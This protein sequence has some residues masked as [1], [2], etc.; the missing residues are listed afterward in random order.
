[1]KV[2]STFL[3]KKD[4][5]VTLGVTERCIY[6]YIKRGY[7]RPVKDGKR[8]GVRKE[9]VIEFQECMNSDMPFPV[10]KITMSR[11]VGQIRKLQE[12]MDTVKRMLNLRRRSIDLTGQELSSAYASAQYFIANGCPMGISE[13]WSDFF[14]RLTE[15]DLSKM[16]KEKEDPHPWRV[17]YKLCNILM[18]VA[19]LNKDKEA[20][21]LLIVG[22]A[23]LK[24]LVSIW[25]EMVGE[26][27]GRMQQLYDRDSALSKRVINR[28]R[29]KGPK[30]QKTA[31]YL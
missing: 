12:E 8:V 4:A 14:V 29:E 23:N 20:E 2:G 10:N 21:E 15:E 13:P 24:T 9:D 31:Y 28:I 26:S 6:N 11:L 18:E 3:S 22:R 17:F 27:P 5:S 1:M 16:A 25:T 19:K 7:L 30:V